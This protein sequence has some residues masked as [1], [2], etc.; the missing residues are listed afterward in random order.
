MTNNMAKV[1]IPGQMVDH[2]LASGK[3]VSFMELVPIQIKKENLE[4]VFGR[5]AREPNGLKKMKRKKTKKMMKK[6]L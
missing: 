3:K 2:T 5:M 6:T 4:K 1:N